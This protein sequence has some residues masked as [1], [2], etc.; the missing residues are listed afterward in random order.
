MEEPILQIENLHTSFHTR[1][2]EVQAVR[3]LSFQLQKGEILGIVG[4]SGSGKSVT[5]LSILDVLPENAF[6]T[7]GKIIFEGKDLL[8]STKKEL[9]KVRGGQISMVFQDPMTSL[10]PL[11][12]IGKQIE[13][14]ILQN[15]QGATKEQAR[16]KA[17]EMLRKVHIP[18]PESRY[19][20]YPHEL[21]GGMRQRVM[22]AIALSC[23]PKI[24]IADEPTTALDVTIQKQ[25]LLLLKEM[26]REMQLS[27]IFITHDLGVVAQLCDRVVVLYGGLK[28]EEG[29][30]FE[31]F[32][33]P[34]HPYTMG[35][36]ESVPRVN[37]DKNARLQPIPGS[38]PDL[39]SPPQGCPF[40]SRCRYARRLCVSERPEKIMLSQTH[41][42]A[43]WLN[44][45]GAPAV[46]NPFAE[47][48]VG[49]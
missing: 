41:S 11:M 9:R 30:V 23:D 31:L 35:L 48:Q 21:S 19:E 13:E 7:E 36:L 26:C 44:H 42:S 5:A 10:S 47:R 20:C 38:P 46:G 34:G 45:P 1:A 28:M 22:I 25:I 15:V 3:G 6:H 27:V 32:E 29:T 2:G 43:C 17:L 16:V 49:R 4:E 12:K 8:K 33:N 14:A 40:Y 24:V 39:L 18:D 37:Q